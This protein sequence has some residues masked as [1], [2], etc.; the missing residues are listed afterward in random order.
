LIAACFSASDDRI[1]CS[2]L[3]TSRTTNLSSHCCNW[4]LPP[5][6]TTWGHCLCQ[7]HRAHDAQL[8]AGLAQARPVSNN[9]LVTVDSLCQPRLP[10][11][12]S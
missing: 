4:Q 11:G 2:T 12:P 10:A 8:R 6:K 1:T 5:R 3:R 9:S 7:Q